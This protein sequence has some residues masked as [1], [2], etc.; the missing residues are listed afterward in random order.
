MYTARV[1]LVEGRLW[2][3]AGDQVETTSWSCMAEWY[4][5]RTEPWQGELRPS[6]ASCNQIDGGANLVR[7]LAAI[8]TRSPMWRD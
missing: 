8:P 1:W 4:R 7:R 5:L 2:L 6:C 3:V